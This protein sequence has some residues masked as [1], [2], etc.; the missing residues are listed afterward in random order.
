MS[1]S[2]FQETVKLNGIARSNRFTVSI[3]PPPGLQTSVNI[4][5]IGLYCEE[6]TIPGRGYSTAPRGAG[7]NGL[8]EFVPYDKLYDE[9]NM[10]FR[11]S[12]DMRER[13]FFED[14]FETI[15]SS[16]NGNNNRFAYL[17][18]YATNVEVVQLNNKDDKVMSFKLEEAYP[19]VIAEINLSQS[20]NEYNRFQVTFKYK[21][22]T[23]N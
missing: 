20:P 4:D 14:W 21:K 16:R 19:T 9:I 13:R 17:D 12:Q 5:E 3:T 18:S 11:C 8:Q 2:R 10:V 23:I 1:L 7:V 15:S 6:S 22:Y